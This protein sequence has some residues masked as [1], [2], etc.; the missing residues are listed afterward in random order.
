MSMRKA[1]GGLIAQGLSTS[2]HDEEWYLGDTLKTNRELIDLM[3]KKYAEEGHVK[4]DH[5]K[6]DAEKLVKDENQ[7]IDTIR[8]MAFLLMK[9]IQDDMNLLHM[10]EKDLMDA[11]REAQADEKKGLDH[12]FATKIE[13]HAKAVKKEIDDMQNTV[14]WEFRAEAKH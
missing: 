14:F 9:S 2:V 11:Y 4:D 5:V 13:G 3:K 1:I 8:K 7:E 6:G 10:L 12:S